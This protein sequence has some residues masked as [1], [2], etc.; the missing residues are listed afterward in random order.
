MAPVQRG[1]DDVPTWVS[2]GSGR[3]VLILPGG[4]LGKNKR[5]SRSTG[6]KVG[7]GTNAPSSNGCAGSLMSIARSPPAYQLISATC[8]NTVWLCELK[9]PFFWPHVLGSFSGSLNSPSNF[10]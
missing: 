7:V 1:A 8:G 3:A 10:G 6:V 9:V 5:S 2:V 4:E